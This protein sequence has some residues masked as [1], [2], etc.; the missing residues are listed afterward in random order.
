MAA[1]PGPPPVVVHEDGVRVQSNGWVTITTTSG[2]SGTSGATTPTTD[3]FN[4][5]NHPGHITYTSTREYDE[6]ALPVFYS[7]EDEWW[8]VWLWDDP[9]ELDGPRALVALK[10][11]LRYPVA[12]P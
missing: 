4:Q 7:P 2:A 3:T 10:G 9:P 5:G 6:D 8:I 1:F 11:R 12:E